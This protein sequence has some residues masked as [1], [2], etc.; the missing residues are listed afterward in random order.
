M[1]KSNVALLVV[2]VMVLTVLTTVVTFKQMNERA[3]NGGYNQALSD[4]FGYG[5]KHIQI[6]DTSIETPNAVYNI[7]LK[8]NK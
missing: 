6:N 1:K 4:Y 7:T 2:G 5:E 8:G 3:Y